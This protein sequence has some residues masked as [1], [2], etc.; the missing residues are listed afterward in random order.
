MKFLH[1]W[2]CV[3]V[4]AT[5]N[6][7][8]HAISLLLLATVYT[9]RRRDRKTQLVLL[10]N[11]CASEFLGNVYN[12]LFALFHL[13]NKSELAH[14]VYRIIAYPNNITF[15]AGLFLITADRLAASSLEL[16]YK[17]I[18]TVSRAKKVVLVTYCVPNLL[19][20]PGF[21]VVFA[22]KGYAAM[23][24]AV[25]EAHDFVFT[26]IQFL[27]SLLIA[28]SY[29][30]IFVHYVKSRRRSTSSEQSV[31]RIFANSKFSVAVMITAVH[32]IFVGI[33]SL[34]SF[35]MCLEHL[36]RNYQIIFYALLPNATGFVDPIIYIFLYAPVR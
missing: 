16:R 17:T 13:Y 6:V 20:P 8:L 19:L 10:S 30:I 31:T 33:P 36:H 26:M 7:F 23:K 27:F 24:R 14:C 28:I 35:T 22:C 1:I 21:A 4:E 34:V 15:F 25:D 5:I 2:Y 29:V 12:L 9:K 3:I 11:F 32:F 18:C